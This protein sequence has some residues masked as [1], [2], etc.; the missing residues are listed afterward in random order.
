[1]QRQDTPAPLRVGLHPTKLPRACIAI[2]T[3]IQT[4]ECPVLL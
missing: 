3:A 1:M 2:Q 4:M